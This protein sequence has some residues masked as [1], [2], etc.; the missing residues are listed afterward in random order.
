MS[1]FDAAFAALMQHEGAYAD[2]PADPGG[3]TKWGITERV[4]RRYGYTGPMADLP[5]STARAIAKTEYWD[6]VRGD[7]VSP[8]LALQLLDAAYNSGPARAIQWLQQ[9]L[10]STGAAVDGVFGPATMAAVRA[11]PNEARLIGRL[12]AFRLQYLAALPTW[13]TFGKGWARRI[14]DNLLR[15]PV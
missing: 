11:Y 14:A 10:G 4:A 12:N 13:A 2:N 15:A 8:A 3:A 9:A 6:S 7:E 1:A 5:Q